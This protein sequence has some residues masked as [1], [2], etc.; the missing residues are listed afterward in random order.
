MRLMK[1]DEGG[2]EGERGLRKQNGLE[3]I[4]RKGGLNGGG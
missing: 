2:R 3:K 4:E 1:D